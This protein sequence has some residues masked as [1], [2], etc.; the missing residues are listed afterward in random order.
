VTS[1]VSA[2]YRGDEMKALFA[3]ALLA[4]FGVLVT[5]C[6]SGSKAGSGSITI[7]GTT[8]ISNVN[9]GTPIRC[10]HGPAGAGVPPPG[11]EVAGF[12][13][14]VPGASGGEIQ[15]KRRQDGSLVASCR[16]SG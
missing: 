14:P 2:A 7:T 16:P 13:D 10:K 6:G 1:E 5:G 9:T 3:L 15:L 4:A 11:Q 8:T 12:A